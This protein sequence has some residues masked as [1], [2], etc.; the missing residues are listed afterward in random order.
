MTDNNVFKAAIDM[1]DQR[2]TSST[3]D[4]HLVEGLAADERKK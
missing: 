2:G 4:D 3:V 1:L